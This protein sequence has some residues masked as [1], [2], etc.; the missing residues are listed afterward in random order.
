[1]V[2]ALPAPAA[3]KLLRQDVPAAAAEL[4]TI[5]TASVA[6]V[7]LAFR[8]EGSDRLPRGSGFL[9]PP[10]D[11]RVIKAATFTTSKW[12]WYTESAPRVVIARASV[13]RFHEE[14]DLQ[15]DDEDLVEAARADLE[16]AT[17]VQATPV[18]ALVTRWE[19]GL[20]QYFVGHRAKVERVRAAVS[21]MPG[22][23]VCGAT[24]DGIGIPACIASAGRAVRELLEQWA[25]A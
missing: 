24:Y 12:P 19:G 6:I 3:A 4:E 7:T 20:P 23:A 1:V 11:N 14:G 5:E 9:V 18:D 8:R 25:D 10:V 16:E 2:L 22:L 15:R 21:E 13:G 17:G